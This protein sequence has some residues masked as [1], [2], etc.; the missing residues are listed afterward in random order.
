[1]EKIHGNWIPPSLSILIIRLYITYMHPWRWIH[2]WDILRVFTYCFSF[3]PVA[4]SLDLFLL[5]PNVQKQCYFTKFVFLLQIIFS[6]SFSMRKQYIIMLIIRSFQFHLQGYITECLSPLSRCRPLSM[7]S[8][9]T[10]TTKGCAAIKFHTVSNE[11]SLE[12]SQK[13]CS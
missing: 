4:R 5:V 2:V 8:R 1:M 7:S 12:S 11:C 13:C 6:L 3:C 9:L 10:F